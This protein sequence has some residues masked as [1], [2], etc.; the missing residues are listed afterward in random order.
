MADQ[1]S[2]CTCHRCRSPDIS[3]VSP[4]LFHLLILSSNSIWQPLNAFF[5]PCS[6]FHF[7]QGW[8]VREL[9]CN[10]P[11]IDGVSLRH[12]QEDLWQGLDADIK[13]HEMYCASSLYYVFLVP[14]S[15]LSSL[16][17]LF[18]IFSCL[19]AFAFLTLST[20]FV[21]FFLPIF[22]F[23]SYSPFPEPHNT[24]LNSCDLTLQQNCESTHREYEKKA[25]RLKQN[26]SVLL[27]KWYFGYTVVQ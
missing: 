5:F 22:F 3:P 13:S 9:G 8:K 10:E 20:S 2:Y 23:F 26:A 11:V 18:C 6:V 24:P 19:P 25:K 4:T 21:H 12:R 14:P 15:H 16:S 17:L 7:K 1:S 27:W